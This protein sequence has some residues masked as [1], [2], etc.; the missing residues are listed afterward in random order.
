MFPLFF[1][2]LTLSFQDP[3]DTELLDTNTAQDL[4]I[5][6]RQKYNSV[7]RPESEPVFQEIITL[8]EGQDTLDE[9]G[10]LILAESYKHMGALTF[11]DQTE[12]W[13]RRLIIFN[14][15]YE[16]TDRDLPPKIEKVFSDLKAQLVGAIR[17]NAIDSADSSDIENARL[18]IDG[19]DVGPIYGETLFPVIAGSRQVEI[20]KRNFDSATTELLVEPGGESAFQGVLFRNAADLVLVTYPAEVN[21]SFQGQDLGPTIDEIPSGFNKVLRENGLNKDK[22]AAITI[23]DLQPGKYRIILTKPCHKP[24]EAPIEI[25]ELKT[26][27]IKPI[28]MKPASASISVKTAS[29]SEGGLLYLGS[30]R[31]GFLPVENHQV[32]PGD[33]QLRVTFTDGDYI[34]NI[35]LADGDSYEVSAEPLPS[36]AWFGLQQS[37]DGKP[38]VDLDASFNALKSWNLIQVDPTD[39]SSVPKNPFPILFGEPEISDENATLL[40]RNTRADLYIAA[41]VVRRKVVIRFLEVA[42]W[43]PLSKKIDIKQFDFREIDKFDA[44]LNQMDSFP[45]LIKPWLG[46]QVARLQD[47]PGCKVIEVSPKGPLAGKLNTSAFIQSLN[48]SILR[49]PSE[50][51]DIPLGQSVTLDTGSEQINI[52]PLPTIAE[53]Y[54]DPVETTPQALLARFEKLSKYHPDELVRQSARF[55]Q[56]RFQLFLGDY[57]RAF[58][59]FSSMTL[60][61]EYGINQGA[62]H[63]YQGLCFRQLKLKNEAIEAFRATTRYPN[64]TLFDAYGPKAALWAEAELSATN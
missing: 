41:R 38:P 14:P 54:F 50:I 9:D 34:K 46:L 27:F 57:K 36:I 28:V 58:D 20:S 2:L 42:I 22:G 15:A 64:A 8:L 32:C 21:V 60:S 4:F 11:P 25:D 52:D 44:L 63:F 45:N 47:L 16:L 7:Q 12:S 3:I 43:S 49:N 1:V 19:K 62:L 55:N 53:V 51:Q 30:E 33:Y 56:A 35:S 48:G 18:I 26:N 17:V 31:V 23:N 13:F 37:E 5:E 29:G 24:F 59:I 10:S 39:A 40:T 6:A 61:M